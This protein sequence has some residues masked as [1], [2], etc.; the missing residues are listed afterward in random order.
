MLKPEERR[1]KNLFQL[2]NYLSLAALKSFKF[3]RIEA[4]C[5]YHLKNETGVFL[6]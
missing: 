4:I 5:R 3:H 6:F 2:D 1:K